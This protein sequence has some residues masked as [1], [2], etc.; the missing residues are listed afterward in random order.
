[1]I[2]FWV[3]VLL[4]RCNLIRRMPIKGSPKATCVFSG[5]VCRNHQGVLCARLDDSLT[6]RGTICKPD[7]G[8]GTASLALLAYADGRSCNDAANQQKMCSGRAPQMTGPR[9]RPA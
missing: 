3:V 1:M 6:R 7:H 5:A 2:S 9:G 8:W 4:R